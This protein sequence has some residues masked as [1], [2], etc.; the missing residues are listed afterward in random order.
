MEVHISAAF[1]WL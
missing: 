1:L